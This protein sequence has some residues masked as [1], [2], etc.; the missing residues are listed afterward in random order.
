VEG[1]RRDGALATDRCRL[2]ALGQAMQV[3]E[4]GRGMTLPIAPERRRRF[5]ADDA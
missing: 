1:C 3:Q 2:A 5:G 4:A